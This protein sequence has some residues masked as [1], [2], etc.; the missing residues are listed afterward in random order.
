MTQFVTPKADEVVN[1]LGMIL[2]DGLEISESE[3]IDLSNKHTATFLDD[4][5]E[6]VAVC[7]CDVPFV[8]YSGAA[9]SMIPSAAAD[10]MIKDQE[11]TEAISDNFY[12]VMNICSKLLMSD[13]SA[14]LRLDKTLTPTE[15]AEAVASLESAEVKKS[16]ELNIPDYGAGS[17]AFA[18]Q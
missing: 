15:A 18:I 2:G 13:T 10:E 9:L 6:L 11:L 8:A 17:I 4:N 5:D 12:E 14:H 1:L 3:A 7:C 16:F